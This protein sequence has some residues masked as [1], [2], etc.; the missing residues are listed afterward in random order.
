MMF[1]TADV[2]KFLI[3]RSRCP[4]FVSLQLFVRMDLF[5]N[6]EKLEEIQCPVL[7]MH[8]TEDDIDP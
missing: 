1:D 4:L 3:S 6:Y 5:R 8:G 2:P 7:V